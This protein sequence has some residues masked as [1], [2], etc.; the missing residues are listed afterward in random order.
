M[1]DW[2][3]SARADRENGMSYRAIAKKYGKAYG[4]V[5]NNLNT[6]EK[7]GKEEPKP[8]YEE[9]EGGYYIHYGHKRR[10]GVFITFEN[11]EEAF[12]LYCIAHLTLNQTSLKMSLTRRE[13]YAIK[14]AFDITKD[15]MP[16]TPKQVDYYTAEELAEK[17]RLKKK[18]YA[19]TK[20]EHNKHADIEN[21]IKQMDTTDFWHKQICESVNQIDARPYNL[22]KVIRDTDYLYAVYIADV[23]AGLEVDNYFNQYNIQIM[24]ERFAKLAQSII[25]IVPGKSIYIADLGDTVHGII[26]GS[27]Q[28]YGTWVTDAT[29]EVIKAYESLFLTLIN[30]GLEINFAK[31]NGSH[32][33]IEKSKQERTEE[34][35]FG[36]FIFDMLQWKYGQLKNIK[37]IPRLKGLNMAILPIFNYSTLLIH[38]DN[39][40]LNKLKD[41]DRLFKEYN[42]KE[43]NAAHFHHLKV[44]DFNGYA[45]HYNE[46]LCGTDQYAGNGLMSSDFGTRLVQYTKEGRGIEQLIRF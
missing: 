14:T 34:E 9:K 6:E 32:E 39:A 30:T 44:E 43:I 37:F 33:S 19:L 45:I 2:I 15:S 25:D 16:F 8:S 20:I 24:H 7:E 11:L 5:Y 41:S 12:N 46:C 17:Y 21:R 23:H 38:G 35:S 28:K 1:E 13:F 22:V 3:K 36:N 27:V 42:V 26:H 18:Q 29:T 4:T 10:N 31:V 40:G